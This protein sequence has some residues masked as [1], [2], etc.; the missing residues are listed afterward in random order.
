[1]FYP[2]FPNFIFSQRIPRGGVTCAEE[3]GRRKSE[4]GKGGEAEDYRAGKSDDQGTGVVV[5]KSSTR[6]AVAN[7][8]LRIV[9][10]LKD[11]LDSK[12]IDRKGELH[13]VILNF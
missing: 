9:V 1:M 4:K 3:G 7:Y 13:V 11:H 2:K 12:T 8:F 6:V 5:T 10:L